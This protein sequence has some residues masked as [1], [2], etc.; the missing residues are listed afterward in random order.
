MRIKKIVRPALKRTPK[1][2]QRHHKALRRQRY[3]PQYGPWPKPPEIDDY[4]SFYHG[5][6]FFEP[7]DFG[8]SADNGGVDLVA[9]YGPV[10]ALASS[11]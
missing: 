10:P 9:S 5:D 7:Q 4:F 6:F 11:L 1:G 2:K 8:V 3:L